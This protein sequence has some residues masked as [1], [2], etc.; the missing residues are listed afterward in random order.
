MAKYE[1][2]KAH[3]GLAVGTIKE[4][5]AASTIADYMTQNGY[6]RK[7]EDTKDDRRK[8]GAAKPVNSKTE[9]AAASASFAVIPQLKKTLSNLFNRLKK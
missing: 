3:D 6:W 5:P 1:V 2:I 9:P 4:M 7:V 8:S